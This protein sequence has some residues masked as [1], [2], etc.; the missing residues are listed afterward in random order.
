MMVFFLLVPGILSVAESLL[1]SSSPWTLRSAGRASVSSPSLESFLLLLHRR[2]MDAARCDTPRN[3]DVGQSDQNQ[4]NLAL[5]DRRLGTSSE[6]K[7]VDRSAGASLA[8]DEMSHG[9]RCYVAPGITHQRKSTVDRLSVFSRLPRVGDAFSSA[10]PH[11]FNFGRCL[12]FGVPLRSSALFACP[13][14]PLL[15]FCPTRVHRPSISDGSPAVWT[16]GPYTR[17]RF[18]LPD[19]SRND[20]VGKLN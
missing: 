7:S 4:G 8:L 6:R 1:L 3:F 13:A 5:I 20:D 10:K 12:T 17:S 15:L 2:K 14:P 9:E 18:A 16:G 19:I 11:N